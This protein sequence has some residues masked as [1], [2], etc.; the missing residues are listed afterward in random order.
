MVE[1]VILGTSLLLTPVSIYVLDEPVREWVLEHHN[2]YADRF[3]SVSNAFGDGKY[4]A[5]VWLGITAVGYA[6]K[7][8]GLYSF[9]KWGTLSFLTTGVAT[10][11]LKALIGRARPHLG[12]GARAFRP[13]NLEDDF[14]SLPSGHTSV[15]FSSA[16][17]VFA[18]TRNPWVRWGG[19]AVASTVGMARIYRDRH[20]LSD[21][22]MGAGV[23]FA[24]GYFVGRL[25][26][27][28]ER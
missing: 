22:I 25:A 12:M 3:F 27:R 18:R 23:G 6:L 10:L 1:G 17:Y 21:V 11:G 7:D 4:H 19:V 8:D 26:E 16:G 28:L 13:L 14:H 24:T 20:W 5:G 9:G 2:P 15:A